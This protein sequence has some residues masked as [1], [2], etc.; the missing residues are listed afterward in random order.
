VLIEGGLAWLPGILWRLETNWCALRGETPWLERNPG[1]VVREHVRFTTQPLE[2]T[3]GHDEL[4]WEM[5]EAAGAPDILLF[6]SDY[7][8]WDF[9]DPGFM[10]QRLP[11]AWRGRV[12]HDNPAEL[13]GARV[14][15]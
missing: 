12:M 9:D 14:A 1:D 10:L 11:N 8:H 13:Y 15:A 7:L 2:H 4:L 5:L 3:N 6:A